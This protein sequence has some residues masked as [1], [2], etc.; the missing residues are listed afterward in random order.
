M[1]DKTRSAVKTELKKKIAETIRNKTNF[2]WKTNSMYQM[3]NPKC[4][5]VK[6]NYVFKLRYS[7]Q[8]DSPFEEDQKTSDPV[9][10]HR[11]NMDEYELF[12]TNKDVSLNMFLTLNPGNVANGGSRFWLEDK[13][14]E[15]EVELKKYETI[16]AFVH[17]I[18]K[19]TEDKLK[20]VYLVITGKTPDGIGLS[21]IKLDIRKL[22][23]GDPDRIS[24]IFSD[25]TTEIKYKIHIAKVLGYLKTNSS[26]TEIRWNGSTDPI[27]SVPFGENTSNKLAEFCLSEEGES[28]MQALNER[29]K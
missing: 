21:K 26:N 18:N 13:E 22:G 6:D 14:M 23:E 4:T 7:S 28:V 12:T 16:D 29:L 25:K 1:A 20:A 24:K 5:I 2:T 27:V 9:R 15:A 8:F 19:S 17:L 11:I 10:L 3:L